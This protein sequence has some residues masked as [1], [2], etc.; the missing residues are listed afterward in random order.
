[1][2]NKIEINLITKEQQSV[3]IWNELVET[4]NLTTSTKWTTN[5]IRKLNENQGTENEFQQMEF[6]YLLNVS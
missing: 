1:M 4:G 6:H 5:Q 2:A 3:P